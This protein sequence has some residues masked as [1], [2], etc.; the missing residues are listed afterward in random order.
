M[1]ALG[2][3]IEQYYEGNA[4]GEENKDEGYEKRKEAVASEMDAIRN[5]Y[6]DAIRNGYYKRNS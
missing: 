5:G 6:Y 3:A 4:K 1:S 2:K